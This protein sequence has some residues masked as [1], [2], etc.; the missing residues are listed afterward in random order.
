MR[1]TRS[2]TALATVL[3]GAIATGCGGP[4]DEEQVRGLV[5]DYLSA[6]ARNDGEKVCSLLTESAQKQIQRGAGLIRGKNCA[7]TMTTL[8]KISTEA[9]PGS[10]KLFHA[11][12]VVVDGNEAGVII[13]PAAPGAK[14]TKLLKVDGKWLIDGSVSVSGK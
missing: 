4:S 3:A 12:K 7:E 14:P 13:Q 10:L 8:S 11:G 9:A 2:Q 1:L 5:G 6:F